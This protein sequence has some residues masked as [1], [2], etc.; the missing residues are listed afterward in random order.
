MLYTFLIGFIVVVV[1]CVIPA[2]ISEYVV[3]ISTFG[4]HSIVKYLK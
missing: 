4:L 1:D 3:K 2:D